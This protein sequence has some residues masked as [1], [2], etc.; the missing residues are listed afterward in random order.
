MLIRMSVFMIAATLAA[1]AGMVDASRLNSVSPDAG[2]GN[3]LLYAVGAA[4][5][6]G[7]GRA[8]DA[9]PADRSSR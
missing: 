2:A 7:K 4:V 3:A 1:V 5:I 9:V 6:G 8:R